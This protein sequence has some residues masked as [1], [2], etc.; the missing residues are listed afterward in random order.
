MRKRKV[1]YFVCSILLLILLDQ[2]TKQI[3][4][5]VFVFPENVMRIADTIHIHPILNDQNLQSLL[6][7]AETLSV[8]VYFLLCI[9]AVMFSILFCVGVGMCYQIHSFFFWDCKKKSYVRLNTAI[10]CLT[11]AGMLCS[12]Y[13][14]ELCF[15]GSLDW[16]CCA[17]ERVRQDYGTHSHAVVYHFTFDL[18]DIYL[19]LGMGLFVLRIVLF[20]IT[21]LKST[22][23]EQKGYDRKL[24][25]PLQNI[26]NRKTALG[27]RWEKTT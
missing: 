25:H 10:L 5:H 24:K 4:N 9:R 1:L 21:Y 11:V 13:F 16:I 14:D 2:G 19:W 6:P 26:R 27:R 8:N 3:V 7:I 22:E 20:L 15:G 18:K 12:V 23:E 17:W